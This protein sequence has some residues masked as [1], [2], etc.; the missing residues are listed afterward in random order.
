M[1]RIWEDPRVADGLSR[2]FTARESVLR[3]GAR[4]LGWKVG[5]GAP[6]SLELMQISA[7]LLGFLTDGTLLESG[8]VVDVATWQRG[9]V[10]FEV[11]VRLGRDLGPGASLDEAR[12]AVAALGPAIE[13]ANIDLPIEASRVGDIVAGDIFHEGL[14]VGEFDSARSGLDI[15]GLTARILIDG[16]ERAATS[17]LEAI[18]GPYPWIVATV[19]NTVAAHGVTLSEGD[20]II[21]GSVVPPIPVTEGREFVFALGPYPP[22]SVRVANS[23]NPATPPPR[24]SSQPGTAEPDRRTS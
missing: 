8:T 5:F 17:E 12:E 23:G 6:A 3:S 16:T 20:I 24:P 9:I 15:E 7:P 14:I 21:T 11:A 18:T 2:Q 10:E 19:A 1:T 22:L 4:S 13:L